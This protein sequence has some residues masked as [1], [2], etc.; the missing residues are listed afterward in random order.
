[1]RRNRRRY[2]GY[3]V[4][5]GMALLFVGVAASSAFQH[6]RDVRLRAGQTTKVG[7]YDVRYVTPDGGDRPRATGA[8]RRSS[9]GAV[10]DVTKNGKHVDDAAAVEGYFPSR[11]RRLG[12]GQRAS[13]RARRRARSA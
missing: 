9:L 5:V 4:H 10:L 6:A 7:G 1:M 11:T 13:S 12:A 8:S 3:I 2:G